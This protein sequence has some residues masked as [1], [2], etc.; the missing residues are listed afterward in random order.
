MATVNIA[1]LIISQLFKSE[2]DVVKRKVGITQFTHSK[3]Q[4]S[5]PSLQVK[6]LLGI[7]FKSDFDGIMNKVAQLLYF[8]LTS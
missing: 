2:L 3:K 4:H 6:L 8:N 5:Y 1:M 7:I